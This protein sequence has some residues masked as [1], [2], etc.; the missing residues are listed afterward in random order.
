MHRP[1]SHLSKVES[2]S[3]LNTEAAMTCYS[4]AVEAGIKPRVLEQFLCR[5]PL[6]R[7]PFEHSFHEFYEHPL[8]FA[9]NVAQLIYEGE[10]LR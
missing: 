2:V 3:G 10:S 8:V 7:V 1:G 4:F 6:F 9:I 5:T